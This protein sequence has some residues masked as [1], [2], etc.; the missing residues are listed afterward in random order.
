M[1]D[2]DGGYDYSDG[3]IEDDSSSEICVVYDNEDLFT[4]LVQGGLA[5]LA[6]LSLWYKRH[7]ERPQRTMRV[8]S[9]D[10]SKQAVGA[11]YA[12]VLNMC[13]AA[14]IATATLQENE[15]AILA[16]QCA[17]YGLSYV[18]DTTLGLV[19][20]IMGVRVLEWFA[21]KFSCLSHL[22][23]SGVY[24][25]VCVWFSQC[26]AWLLVLTITKVI[27]YAVMYT[28]A[29]PLAYVGKLLFSPFTGHKHLELLFVMIFFPGVLNIIYF[30]VADS[31]LMA[32]REQHEA[33][34]ADGD[35]KSAPLLASQL[36]TT[37][38]N[39]EVSVDAAAVAEAYSPAPWS[40]LA[41]HRQEA[42]A[43]NANNS[44]STST[45]LQ[46]SNYTVNNGQ[47]NAN[48]VEKV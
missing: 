21:Q 14:I 16:D 48:T 43:T 40:I 12:H 45:T 29:T 18:I 38:L 27:I 47:D 23:Q 2:D 5:V 1:A 32:N 26:T 39:G 46:M 42:Q 17:W 35:K 30:W 25:N 36:S 10:V 28:F 4:V 15:E 44:G 13:I 41:H 34:T 7:T 22:H 11:C 37:S 31:Y 3:N 20:V 19:L 9:M 8:W 33:N 6:L 24:D